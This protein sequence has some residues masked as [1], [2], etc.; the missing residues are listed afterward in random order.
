MGQKSLESQTEEG[1]QAA[2][3]PSA[4]QARPLRRERLP[5]NWR[6]VRKS[7]LREVL[8]QGQRFRTSLI[9]LYWKGNRVGHPRLGLIVPRFQHTAVARNRL[10]RRLREI[11]RRRLL[12]DLPAI[13]LLIRP[14]PE[15]Y[16]ADWAD[17]EAVLERWARSVTR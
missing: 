15:A 11:A 14:K 4:I 17:L 13:D 3:S 7:D 2:G 8:L 9:E 10:R 16:A 5:R 12:P 6:L 1:A